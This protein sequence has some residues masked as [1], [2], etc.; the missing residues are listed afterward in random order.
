VLTSIIH[1]GSTTFINNQKTSEEIIMHSYQIFAENIELA[2]SETLLALLQQPVLS[3]A[4]V[5]KIRSRLQILKTNATQVVLSEEETKIEAERLNL[6]EEKINEITFAKSET[7][8]MRLVKHHANKMDDEDGKEKVDDSL[9]RSNHFGNHPLEID[10]VIL[11]IM[12]NFSFYDRFSFSTTSSKFHQVINMM[13]FTDKFIFIDDF[14]VSIE[15]LGKVGS[16]YNSIRE[17]ETLEKFL[18]SNDLL[19]NSYADVVV[20]NAWD[21]LPIDLQENLFNR[22]WEIL[23]I[24]TTVGIT[25]ATTLPVAYP[26]FVYFFKEKNDN[27]TLN[28]RAIRDTVI[29]L[30]SISFLLPVIAGVIIY[31]LRAAYLYRQKNDAQN[32]IS[33]F[34]GS[35]YHHSNRGIS[36]ESGR[37]VEV[38]SDDEELSSHDSG[39]GFEKISDA[40][41]ANII[42]DSVI[43]FEEKEPLLTTDTTT[44]FR[45]G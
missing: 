30:G 5:R 43:S 2:T 33:E 35:F 1:S 9:S 11:A 19:T 16:T 41:T 10:E 28:T 34:Y 44:T 21:E 22:L 32:R 13:A 42:N 12:Q 31:A 39:Q 36:P 4:H 8:Q 14:I 29:S 3:T 20:Q 15:Q 38:N 40:V 7:L 25:F 45:R 37:V 27:H 26:F 6:I 18:K 17:D 23:R 24:S